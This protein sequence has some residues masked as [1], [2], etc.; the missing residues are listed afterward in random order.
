MPSR[1]ERAAGRAVAIESFQL[2]DAWWVEAYH[3]DP[4]VRCRGALLGLNRPKA[5][6][7]NFAVVIAGCLVFALLLFL[8]PILNDGDTL[9]QIRAG[10]WILDHHAIPATD[11]FSF[12]AGDR[13]WFAHEWLAETLMAFAYRAGG[14]KGVMVLAAATTGL[15]AG[16]LLHHLRRF[17]PGVYASTGLVVALCLAAPSMLARP[18][19]IAW[20]CLALWCGGL[21][22]ARANRTTPA[23]ALLLVMLVWVNLHGSFTLGLLLPGASMRPFFLLGAALSV[24]PGW[25]RWSTRICSLACCFRFIWW[26]CRASPGSE[27]GSPPISLN[28]SH[29]SLSPWAAWRLACLGAS[30]CLRSG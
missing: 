15:T 4:S 17:L 8:P 26:A 13:R 30:D 1:L 14:L 27:S 18:H 2:Q 7:L 24:L 20:P 11:P 6:H 16:V 3:D 25:W 9:W 19:L 12:T 5:A 10:E 23:W 28:F 21:V 22:R 29:L